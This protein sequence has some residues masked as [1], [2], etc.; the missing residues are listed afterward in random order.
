[1]ATHQKMLITQKTYAQQCVTIVEKR[2]GKKR[3]NFWGKKT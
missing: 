3:K 2:L 1:M